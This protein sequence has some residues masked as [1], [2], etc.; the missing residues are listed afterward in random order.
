MESWFDSHHGRFKRVERFPCVPLYT[1][2][3]RTVEMWLVV[4]VTVQVTMVALPEPPATAVIHSTVLSLTLIIITVKRREHHA[5]MVVIQRVTGRP[6]VVSVVDHILRILS[7][8]L[9]ETVRREVM[10]TVKIR[11]IDAQY[12][13]F[14][15]CYQVD[16]L[17]SQPE[18]S[19]ENAK[20]LLILDP[21]TIEFHC[22]VTTL[23]YNGPL[24]LS[25]K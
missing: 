2:I 16:F 8:Y 14:L 20:S 15:L 11:E 5:V 18:V 7:I 1:T 12:V 23:L 21:V 22:R 4:I 13:L 24:S 9:E 17:I 6:R 25:V 3:I 19:A 10:D